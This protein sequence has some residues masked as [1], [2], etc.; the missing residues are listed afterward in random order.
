V[1]AGATH[2]A[3]LWLDRLKPGGQ[4]LVPLTA[5]RW[6]GFLLLLTRPLA[7]DTSLIVL[8]EGRDENR[9]EASSIGGVGIFPC[10]GGRDD[11]AAARLQ[12]ILERTIREAQNRLAPEIPIAA[13]YRGE[14]PADA[15]DRVWY[16]APDCWLERKSAA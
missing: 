12:T 8:P 11:E 7:H 15:G 14:A 2:P 3:P 13:L 6:F 9:F 16:T 4:L 5:A 1:F 10:A